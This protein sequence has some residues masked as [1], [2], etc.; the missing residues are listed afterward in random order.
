MYICLY[1]Y[2]YYVLWVLLCVCVCN[3]SAYIR[4]YEYLQAEFAQ[5]LLRLKE[6][7]RHDM[8]EEK[9]RY[10]R[11]YNDTLCAVTIHY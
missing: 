9:A 5:C 6:R 2:D 10:V 1:Y 3:T 4:M 7:M 11:T 8:E